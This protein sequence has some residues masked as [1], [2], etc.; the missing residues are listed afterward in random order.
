[1]FYLLINT[2]AACSI[3]RAEADAYSQL[4]LGLDSGRAFLK[5]MRSFELTLSFEQRIKDALKTR[6]F[7]TQIIWGKGD[8]ALRLKKYAPHLL[9]ALALEKCEVVEGMHFVQEDSS[10]SITSAIARFVKPLSASVVQLDSR[11]AN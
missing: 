7:P 1:M 11:T 6:K 4:L 9:R 2:L 8:P 10:C 3:S 5:I